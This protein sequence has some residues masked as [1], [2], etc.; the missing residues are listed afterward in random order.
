[1]AMIELDAEWAEFLQGTRVAV[2]GVARSG[3]G[4]LLAPVWYGYDSDIGFRFIMS[5]HSAKARRLRVE[6][7]ASIC[8]QDD[9]EQYAHITAEGPVALRRLDDAETK[10]VIR[11]IARRYLGD[12]AGDT[13]T[14]RFSEPDIELVTL[15]PQRWFA[16]RSGNPRD[17]D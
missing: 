9:R 10:E 1:M 6:G 7:R 15:T 17:D 14:E 8:V 12:T 5:R 2:V 4:P 16:E 3:A 11:P 13:W